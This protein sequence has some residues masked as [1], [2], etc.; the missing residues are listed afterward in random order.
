MKKLVALLLA[1][2]IVCALPVVAFAANSPAAGK[3][4]QVTVQKGAADGVT[5][6]KNTVT[7]EQNGNISLKAV[8]SAGKFNSWKVYKAVNAS[9]AAAA[10]V[11]YVEATVNVDYE[12]VSGSLTSTAVT[13]KPLTD[14][15]VCGNYDGK[16]TDPQTGAANSVSDQTGYHVALLALV[17]VLAVAGAGVAV[18]KAI[19]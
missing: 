8:E 15:V 3:V 2:L 6:D 19:A 7:V 9:S 5:S 13:I 11:K 14:I 17:C 4:F 12:I 1:A 16:I 18:K 10:S